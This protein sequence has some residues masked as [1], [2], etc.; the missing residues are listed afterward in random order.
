VGGGVGEVVGCGGGVDVMGGLEEGV[1]SGVGA[2]EVEG[3]EDVE[4]GVLLG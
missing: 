3:T 2:G 1:A 4:V